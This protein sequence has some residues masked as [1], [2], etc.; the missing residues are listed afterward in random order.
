MDRFLNNKY[1]KMISMLLILIIFSV[2][3]INTKLVNHLKNNII[4]YFEANNYEEKDLRD[5]VN[6]MYVTMSDKKSNVIA[7]TNPNR[8]ISNSYSFSE[9]QKPSK[10]PNTTDEYNILFE[11]TDTS[12]DKGYT[13]AEED[14]IYSMD[15]P[16]YIVP[17]NAY[18]EGVDVYHECQNFTRKGKT[19]ACGGI[20]QEDN[21]YKF[22]IIFKEVLN[23]KDVKV[24]YQ[25]NI[26]LDKTIEDITFDIKTIDFDLPGILQLYIEKEEIIEQGTDYTLKVENNG[27][28]SKTKNYTTWTTS[29][30][31]NNDNNYEINGKLKIEF[32]DNH[33]YQMDRNNW[34]KD[35][36]IYADGKKL[37]PSK[38]DDESNGFYVES[39][40]DENLYVIGKIGEMIDFPSRISKYNDTQYS[41]LLKSIDFM[42]SDKNGNDIKGI[43]KWD[44][45]IKTKSYYLTTT[46][47][48]G[49][50]LQTNGTFTDNN[51]PNGN[52]TDSAKITKIIK[53]PPIINL[54]VNSKNESSEHLPDYLEYNTYI[55]GEYDN[56]VLVIENNPVVENTL[57]VNYYLESA[58]FS[59]LNNELEK[60]L[61]IKIDGNDIKFYKYGYSLSSL[62]SGQVQPTDPGVQQQMKIIDTYL[63]KESDPYN[64]STFDIFISNRKNVDGDYYWLIL[65][66]ETAETAESARNENFIYRTMDTNK[67]SYYTPPAK[68]KIYLFNASSQRVYIRA[69]QYLR[70]FERN[71]YNNSP[72]KIGKITSRI[73]VNGKNKEIDYQNATYN[74]M[75]IRGEKIG[76]NFIKW[77]VVLFPKYMNID[78]YSINTKLLLYLPK[79]QA[80]LNNYE[81]DYVK[82]EISSENN[83]NKLNTGSIYKCDE[84]EINTYNSNQYFKCNKYSFVNDYSED[85]WG[86]I[87]NREKFDIINDKLDDYYTYSID[88]HIFNKNRGYPIYLTFFTYIID[89]NKDD[90]NFTD[91]IRL[92]LA[93]E[94]FKKVF[95]D[96]NYSGGPP[97]PSFEVVNEGRIQTERLDKGILYSNYNQGNN[98]I[99]KGF[100]VSSNFYENIKVH[101]S[102]YVD[103]PDGKRD[104][105]YYNGKY[106]LT[107]KFNA[108]NEVESSFA[109]NTKID[110]IQLFYSSSL[111]SF[112]SLSGQ[113]IHLNDY[114]KD[115]EG[116]YNICA[117]TGKCF[118][119]RYLYGDNCKEYNKNN[120]ECSLKNENMLNGFEI[121]LDA[122]E[123]AH[124]RFQY[125]TITDLNEVT[126]DI[127]GSSHKN[128]K[129]SIEIDSELN[130][131]EA[132]NKSNKKITIS[133]DFEYLADLSINKETIKSTDLNYKNDSKKQEVIATIGYTSSKYL[134]ITDFIDGISNLKYNSETKKYDKE[135]LST[136]LNKLKEIRKYIDI[137]NLKISIQN[138]YY[139]TYKDIYS[140]GSFISEYTGSTLEY[141]NNSN[142]L[143]KLHL[144]RSDGED[145]PALTDVKITYNM[146]FHPD[147]ENN[148]RLKDV[149]KGGKFYISTNVEGIRTYENTSNGN[150]EGLSYNNKNVIVKKLTTQDGDYENRIDSTNHELIA[151]AS[152]EGAA[153][154]ADYL[155]PPKI[156]K[157]SLGKDSWEITYDINSTG[158]EEKPK[159][160]ITD[161]IIFNIDGNS[162]YNDEIIPILK[163]YTKYKN[164]KIYYNGKNTSIENLSY[165]IEKLN[166]N[167]S[168]SFND[169][170]GTL[171]CTNTSYN[172]D[173]SGFNY[174]DKVIITYDVD[175][176]YESAIKEMYEKGYIDE[177]NRLIDTNK[178]IKINYSNGASN[179]NYVES[180]TEKSGSYIS[181]ADFVPT[182]TKSNPLNNNDES[183]WELKFNTGIHSKDIKV[184]DKIKIDSENEELIQVIENSLIIKDLIIKYDN[185]IIYE[186]GQFIDNWKDNITIN[187][188]KLGLELLI[189]DTDD[190]TFISNNKEFVISYKTSIDEDKYNSKISNGIFSIENSVELEKDSLKSKDVLI[191][192]DVNYDFPMTINKEFVGNNSNLTETNWKYTI[193]SGRLNRDNVNITDS[194]ELGSNFSKYLSISKL[195]I[196]ENDKVIFDNTSNINNLGNYKLT[197]NNNDTLLFNKSGHYQFK[198]NIPKLNK[199]SKIVVE[200]TLKV[201]DN[202]YIINNEILDN[203]LL[204]KNKLNVT[205]ADN[206][207]LTE[208]V[209]GSS[210]VT[211]KLKKKFQ[212]EGYDS[213]G[214]P[215]VRWFIDVNLLSE[216]TNEEL[217]GKEIIIEDVLS[218]IL[219][220]DP[221]SVRINNRTVTTNS[222][223][224]ESTISNDK[225]KLNTENNTVN[226]KLLD[227]MSTPNLEI[228]FTTNCL[229]SIAELENYV[230]LSVDGKKEEIRSNNQVSLIS[231]YSFGFIQSRED[232]IY[233]IEGKKLLDDKPSNKEFIFRIEE[234]DEEGNLKENGY[235]SEVTNSNDGKITF[236]ALTFTEE[237]LYYYK[238]KEVPGNDKYIKYDDTEYLLRI[239]VK[240][241]HETFIIDN[242]T[243]MNSESK[244]IV[245]NNKTIPKEKNNNIIVNPKTKK[246][247]GIIIYIITILIIAT[248][249]SRRKTKVH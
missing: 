73:T 123:A 232:L 142:E 230:T 140:N 22:K 155:A 21:K 161:S 205:S 56:N 130:S 17:Q 211:S 178:V 47:N 91:P 126:K 180:F 138:H 58:G 212:F 87:Y 150:V 215:R 166:D 77:D 25:F 179:P 42:F 48:Q 32:S 116:N 158:K 124:I 148:Y 182:I 81:Y 85:K 188:N 39:I 83:P 223:S 44:I 129:V 6:T 14:V 98:K 110:Y 36:E 191:K 23:K 84:G 190:N 122:Q 74:P 70:N 104:A 13:K 195:K 237:G 12:G 137:S 219:E 49:I 162:S 139:G 41:F 207:N 153:I 78:D 66:K 222:D 244:E 233:N 88:T 62:V 38:I 108:K 164:I 64:S 240:E 120:N 50:V 242:L 134:D 156:I 170:S 249:I 2:V 33:G 86:Y 112:G 59:Q 144:V 225:Y 121:E 147:K 163:K 218:D 27:Y 221:S 114:T 186:N 132:F 235:Y 1:F 217:V 227:P 175:V 76:N 203:E 54:T 61:T 136:E 68:W 177:K 5:A 236:N 103:K 216:Y 135:D 143:Y 40:S 154:G 7:T 72:S 206:T 100:Y 51:S 183:T 60:S 133:S 113:D 200:Y 97:T 46:D 198:L 105:Y 57:G 65:S 202:E 75:R 117:N 171:T 16:E 167:N 243:I 69:N 239:K 187:I 176:D 159:L 90:P 128:K 35:I 224:I 201:D 19:I 94:T 127:G 45:V 208:E 196:I 210:K 111:E 10:M 102:Y 93:G 24:S 30:I 96:L 157:T 80:I 15:L 248:T 209:N 31:E 55:E 172:L 141:I 165:T 226:I 193:E 229:A 29:I 53:N 168:I 101:D 194:M 146:T 34:F 67:T 82:K 118:K 214:N 8:E 245:F 89:N 18:D 160:N 246:L 79:T 95:N 63:Q 238:V 145:I 151:Y 152:N 20:Y 228:S 173:L 115:S 99:E 26:K 220:L 184:T 28:T 106:I 92:E 125:Y 185:N 189:K 247:F 9:T 234:V 181:V 119:F 199:K 213:N 197:D 241:S 3:L 71:V 174:G 231:P 204:I 109:K 107:E 11:I 131:S 192:S 52:Y 169:I 149:Y 4:T 43:N 37:L